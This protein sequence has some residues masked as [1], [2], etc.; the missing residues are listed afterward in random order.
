[1]I[2]Y[3]VFTDQ[4]GTERFR[5]E[6]DTKRP[7]K[8]LIAKK[9]IPEDELRKLYS[10]KMDSLDDLNIETLDEGSGQS[11][12]LEGALPESKDCIFCGHY[13]TSSKFVNMKKVPLCDEDYQTHTTGEVIA[14][15]R[16]K[17]SEQA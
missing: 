2:K 17:E 10:S 14:Q 12:Q 11:G 1:M 3:S 9:K 4:Y 6:D 5:V 7:R 16:L 13:G 15:L 8:Q